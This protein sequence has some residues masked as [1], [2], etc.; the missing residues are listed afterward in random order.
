MKRQGR[1]FDNYSKNLIYFP[2]E[3]VPKA[4]MEIAKYCEEV[5]YAN[6]NKR[7]EEYHL[8]IKS[9][10]EHLKSTPDNIQLL[11]WLANCYTV[12]DKLSLA[13]STYKKILEIKPASKKAKRLLKDL[14][15]NKFVNF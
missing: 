9:S 1:N 3:L 7:E 12:V 10:L 5:E 8:S 15:E 6:Q 4:I 2:V 11:F 14:L 13:V